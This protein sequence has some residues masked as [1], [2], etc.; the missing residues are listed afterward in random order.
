[1][2]RRHL[3]RA[4]VFA[5][6]VC[7][8]VV[9]ASCSAIP[10]STDAF[11]VNG[12]GYSNSD[13][14][15]LVEVLSTGDQFKISNGKVNA[16]TYS[17]LL[18]TLVRYEAYRQWSAGIG[19]DET[20]ADRAEAESKA[21][22]SQDWDAYPP[23]LQ[24]LV[25]NLNAADI[26]MARAGLPS[27]DELEKMYERSPASTGVV[28]LSHVI[29]RNRDEAVRVLDRLDRGEKF[30]DVAAEVSIE[31][32][33]AETGGS[34]GASPTNPCQRLQDAQLTLDGDFVTAAVGA[35][36]GVPTGPVKSSFGWHVILNRPFDEIAVPLAET[37]SDGTG[38]LL[39]GGWMATADIE[40][41]SK[42]G[43]WNAA[44]GAIE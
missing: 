27:R 4:L 38:V 3:R 5:G 11:R 35:R 23:T 17:T 40:I 33:A 12:T 1:M 8:A 31:P 32:S 28:C 34:L 7:A 24:E 43:T 44:R 41:D 13:F 19:L 22:S 36:A 37:L 20:A 29:V 2:V 14:A 26:V 30:A 39:L 42:F 9:A 15:E 10:S 18:R 6:L 16:D 21:R 25:V